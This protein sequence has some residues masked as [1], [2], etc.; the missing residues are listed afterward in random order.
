MKK[1][2]LVFVASFLFIAIGI[3]QTTVQNLLTENKINPIGIDQTSPRDSETV[4]RSR[5]VARRANAI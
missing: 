2:I 3:A 1:Q 5:A 4:R